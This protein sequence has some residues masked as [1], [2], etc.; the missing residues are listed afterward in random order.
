MKTAFKLFLLALLTFLSG[1]SSDN[2]TSQPAP[3]YWT[4]VS[5]GDRH[6]L[7]I[8]SDGTLWAWGRNNF[9]Q[10]GDGTFDD[11]LEPVQIGTDTNWKDIFA[12][13]H[14]SMA[15]K[16]NGRLWAWGGNEA[17]QL[18]NNSYDAQ[19]SPVA[20]G[21]AVWTQISLGDLF[22]VGL[23][24]NGT[25]WAWG[26]NFWGQVGVGTDPGNYLTPQQIGTGNDWMLI[27]AGSHHT[28]AKKAN[29]SLWGWGS[30]YI[31][32]L[33]VVE[34]EIQFTPIQITSLAQHDWAALSAG[35]HC[36]ALKP[37]GKLYGWGSNLFGELGNPAI[38]DPA[39]LIYLLS[40]DT[41][42][43]IEASVSNSAGIKSNG[44]LWLWGD[45]ANGELAFGNTAVYNTPTQVGSDSDWKFVTTGSYHGLALKNNNQLWSWGQPQ[46]IGNGTDSGP[47]TPVLIPCPQ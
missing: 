8:R 40:S 45:N 15:I 14:H 12:G 38:P 27:A 35:E 3:L 31:N 25:L 41:W 42:D 20:I 6:T 24:Q 36:L 26:A 43:M 28:L 1:C 19:P 39:D 33:F 46:F 17:G 10:L 47:G 21:N 4:K 30:S 23:Q 5:A 13:T 44:T 16:L 22:S 37:N 18:G 32:Q 34:N 9:G 11:R 7:A 29:G 2:D